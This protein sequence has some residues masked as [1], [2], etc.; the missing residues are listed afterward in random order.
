MLCL[1]V[2]VCFCFCFWYCNS[3]SFCFFEDTDVWLRVKIY[4]SVFLLGFDR[5]PLVPYAYFEGLDWVFTSG[6]EDDNSAVIYIMYIINLM[7]N[8][9]YWWFPAR[10]ACEVLLKEA[11]NLV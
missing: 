6:V 4:G 7:I 11:H 2:L 8:E 3:F 5:L 10:K 9:Y 1:A